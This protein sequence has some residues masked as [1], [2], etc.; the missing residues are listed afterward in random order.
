MAFCLSEFVEGHFENAAWWYGNGGEPTWKVLEQLEPEAQAWF[1]YQIQQMPERIDLKTK[2]GK[3]I[4]LTHAGCDPWVDDELARLWGLKNRYIWDR[5]HIHSSAE[6]F[7]EWEYAD[8]YVIHGHTPV[9]SAD[10]CGDCD[11]V[12]PEHEKITAITYADG[13]KICLDL[14]TILTKKAVL[15]DLDTFEEIYFTEEGVEE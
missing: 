7:K 6:S 12:L 5:K 9:I 15:F 14:C 13:H 1:Y 11:V 4:I 8:T 2:D 3:K 10:F